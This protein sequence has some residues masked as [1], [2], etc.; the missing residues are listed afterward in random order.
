MK[1]SAILLIMTMALFSCETRK[2]ADTVYYHATIYTVDSLMTHVEA[3][4][5]KDGKIIAT[6]S[7]D[8]IRSH[9]SAKN[10]IDLQGKYVYPGFF[11]A[12]CHFYGYGLGL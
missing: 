12:H 8:E 4:A 5:V 1:Q 11:D 9:Y 2:A 6:G 10:W 7:G 3:M